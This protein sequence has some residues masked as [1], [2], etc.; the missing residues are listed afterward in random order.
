MINYLLIILLFTLQTGEGPLYIAAAYGH[1][2]IV[3]YLV[4][5][6]ADKEAR[7]KVLSLLY[8]Y[9]IVSIKANV[10][11]ESNCRCDM[12][13]SRTIGKVSPPQKYVIYV[14]VIGSLIKKGSYVKM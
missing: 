2:G 9:S 13:S 11:L 5:C 4:E 14:I 12:L 8:M 7:K 10:R 1:L 6:G 3:K